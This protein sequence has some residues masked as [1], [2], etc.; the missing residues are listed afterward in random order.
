MAATAAQPGPLP[1]CAIRFLRLRSTQTSN[2]AIPTRTAAPARL[3]CHLS[4]SSDSPSTPIPALT[5]SD[6]ERDPDHESE[7]EDTL[8]FAFACGG[9]GAGGRVYSAIALA[10]ELHASLPSSRS[11]ILGA[12]APSV[13]SCRRGLL[14]VRSRPAAL[15]PARDPRRGAAPPPIP[16][17]RPCCYRRRSRATGLP[18]CAH[19]PPPLR[20]TGPGR[21]S[22]SRHPPSRSLRPPRF[23]RLQRSRATPPQ[24]QVRRLRE[25]RPHVHPQVQR[26]QD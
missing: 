15:P 6:P 2:L 5:T 11:L 4:H 26:I 12:P 25:P 18:R 7:S 24:T 20:D 23:P 14:P 3:R 1:R 10:D 22:G 21:L 13:L 16:P 19:A 17:T 8:R 9:A